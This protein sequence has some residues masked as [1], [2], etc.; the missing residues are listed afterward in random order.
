MLVVLLMRNLC[1]VLLSCGDKAT[2]TFM[3]Q[4]V[5]DLWLQKPFLNSCCPVVDL[6]SN[7]C[8]STR[9][10]HRGRKGQMNYALGQEFGYNFPK[11]QSSSGG[12]CHPVLLCIQL[13]ILL[14]T[15]FWLWRMDFVF[16]PLGIMGWQI[17]KWKE[18]NRWNEFIENMVWWRPWF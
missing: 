15:K 12:E 11:W 16:L 9:M 7:L 8:A 1:L 18:H 14:L 5:T 10:V 4:Q 2:S 13:S 6:N 17:Y 3:A